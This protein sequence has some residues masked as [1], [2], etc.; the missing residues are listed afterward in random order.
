VA[1]RRNDQPNPETQRR[2]RDFANHQSLVPNP[3]PDGTEGWDEYAPF[4]DWENART[5]GRRDVPFWR[6]LAARAQGRILELGCGTGRLSLPL[7]RSGVDLVGVDRSAGMLARLAERADALRA[8]P[9]RPARGRLVIIRGD[10]RALP[11][12]PNAFAMVLAPYGVLQSLLRRGDLDATFESVRRVLKPGGLFGIDVVPD[13]TNWKEYRDRVQLRGQMAKGVHLTL[14]ESVRQ[15]HR[16]HLT[17]FEQRYVQRR[18]R[19][20]TEH[21]FELTFR[22][23]PVGQLRTLVEGAGFIVEAVLGDYRGGPWDERA[24]VW[25]ILA[26]KAFKE[27]SSLK[28]QV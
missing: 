9:N 25:L 6:R 22:T 18:G 3:F 8:R 28:S 1:I 13:V 27:V 16:H 26:R 11:F 2:A 12:A 17:T 23:L 4:Y 19:Q 5:L 21:R 7:A 10:I 20:T 14:I 15:D 24:D